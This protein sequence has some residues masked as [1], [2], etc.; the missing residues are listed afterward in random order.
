MNLLSATVAGFAGASGRIN[1]EPGQH[2]HERRNPLPSDDDL[3]MCRLLNMPA[4][5]LHW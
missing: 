1:H 5:P 2:P 3:A 4:P